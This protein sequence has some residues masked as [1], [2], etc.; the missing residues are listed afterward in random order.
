ML[1]TNS[2]HIIADRII[3]DRLAEARRAHLL[4]EIRTDVPEFKEAGRPVHG[5][6]PFERLATAV[7]HMASHGTPSQIHP[8]LR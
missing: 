1:D 6:S 2:R 8:A 5:P 3:E 7:R 4:R